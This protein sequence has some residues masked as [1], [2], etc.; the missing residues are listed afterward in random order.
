[1]PANRGRQY[2]LCYD[3]RDPRRLARVHRLLSAVAVPLQYSVFTG[4]YGEREL[5]GILEGIAGLIDAR[6]DDVR[7]YPLPEQPRVVSIGRGFFPAGLLLVERGR[8]LLAPDGGRAASAGPAR[9][10]W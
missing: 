9:E 5:T 3:I 8:D 10:G 7:V 1:M 4:I 2:L 6:V